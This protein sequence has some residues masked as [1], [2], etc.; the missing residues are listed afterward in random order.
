MHCSRAPQRPSELCPKRDKISSPARKKSAPSTE[1]GRG[2][3]LAQQFGKA[4]GADRSRARGARTTDQRSRASTHRAD[5][6]Q[7]RFDQNIE[8]PR[9]SACTCRRKDR[10]A[11]RTQ[12][13][14]GS[15]YPGQ[16]HQ[17][18]KACRG[19][20]FGASARTHGARCC[21]RRAGG[22]PQG[23]FSPARRSRG[24]S[25]HATARSYRSR[26][27][28]PPTEAANG[29]APLK[30]KRGKTAELSQIEAAGKA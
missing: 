5:R 16:P 8:G 25:I 18:R 11:D 14:P 19:P 1:I 13:P 23:Q 17:H 27:P 10:R 26:V 15:R 24:S 7:Q 4:A 21:R 22:G 20:E 30:G 6:T 29:E 28:I 9:N 12:W 3:H 2:D